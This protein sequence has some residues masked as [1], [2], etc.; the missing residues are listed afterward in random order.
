M[1]HTTKSKKT[2]SSQSP[3]SE[4]AANQSNS[5]FQV[6]FR[7]NPVGII[8]RVST[9]ENIHRY[10]RKRASTNNEMAYHL[11]MVH[12]LRR[13]CTVRLNEDN[14]QWWRINPFGE[15]ERCAEGLSMG[16]AIT[17]SVMLFDKQGQRCEIHS[18]TATTVLKEL[19]PM[20]RGRKEPWAHQRSGT[21]SV[22]H[23]L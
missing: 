2:C 6:E 16:S 4:A 23:A 9:R 19:I 22:L 21:A 1:G 15:F 14:Q 18:H 3:F 5:R 11:A 12:P 13:R 10:P 20:N 17:V 8:N 7:R